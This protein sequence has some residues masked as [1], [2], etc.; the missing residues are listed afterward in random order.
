QDIRPVSLLKIRA[1]LG[2]LGNQ[3]IPIYGYASLVG[4]IGYYPFNGIAVPAYT[5]Y[6]KG[7]PN[8]KWET[9]TITDIGIDLGLFDGALT[10]TGDYYRKIT[11]NLLVNP[12]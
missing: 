12:P 7:N 4:N 8:V 3:E 10:V 5:V 11:S 1:S 9:S 6:Q 2:Q